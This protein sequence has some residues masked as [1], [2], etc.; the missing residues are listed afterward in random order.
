MNSKKTEKLDGH[1]RIQI[2]DYYNESGHTQPKLIEKRCFQGQTKV[3]HEL[4]AAC[5]KL[6]SVLSVIFGKSGRHIVDGL[7]NG[8]DL[9]EIS[10]RNQGGIGIIDANDQQRLMNLI[11]PKRQV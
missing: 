11:N 1:D 6:S 2:E 3:T 4:D 9:E 5:I 7:L 8:M 10:F